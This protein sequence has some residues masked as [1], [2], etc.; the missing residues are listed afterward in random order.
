MDRDANVAKDGCYHIRS[1]YFDDP[2]NSAAQEKLAGVE[3]RKKY[4]IRL[5]NMKDDQIKLEC[6]EKKGS[7][8]HKRS[9]D[10][11]RRA[12]EWLMEGRGI[13]QEEQKGSLSREMHLLSSAGYRPAAIVDY[14][15]EPFVSPYQD[16]RITMDRTLQCG[17]ELNLF[18]FDMPVGL[19]LDQGI[20]ILEV[21][22]NDFLP[23]YYRALLGDIRSQRSAA[24]KYTLCR[25][26]RE[27]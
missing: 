13:P 8:I 23:S 19:V 15:R 1:L 16:I 6:K 27:M 2:F 3:G 17:L 20:S 22:F 5:Y 7:Y 25:Q 18:D 12:A 21:K 4:R 9:E 14:R 26:Y 10:I 11:S 24:S